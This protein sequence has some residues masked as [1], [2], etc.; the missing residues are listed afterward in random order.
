MDVN[1]GMGDCYSIHYPWVGMAVSG[2]CGN[3]VGVGG[4]ANSGREKN[5]KKVAWRVRRAKKRN[6]QRE[7]NDGCERMG[8][9]NQMTAI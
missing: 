8:G 1:L 6:W 7:Q 9:S 4:N 3:R 2:G 5:M